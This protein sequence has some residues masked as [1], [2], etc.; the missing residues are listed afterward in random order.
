[1]LKRYPLSRHA[2]KKACKI[3]LGGNFMEKRKYRHHSVQF[4]E[5]VVKEYLEGESRRELG[6][7]YEISCENISKWRKQYLEL[8]AV[9]LENKKKGRCKGTPGGAVRKKIE[10]DV[11]RLQYENIRLQME[12]MR[13]KKLDEY[14][15]GNAMSK[16]KS[17]HK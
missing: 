15:R 8:G 5:K 7:K 3:Y 17:K 2:N 4:K 11:D 14:L 13:L 1:M 6:K 9:G 10:S 16:S 12:I